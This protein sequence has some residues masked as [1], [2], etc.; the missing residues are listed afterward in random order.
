MIK[1]VNYCWHREYN[2]AGGWWWHWLHIFKLWVWGNKKNWI[3]SDASFSISED[4]L[5]A[6]QGLKKLSYLQSLFCVRQHCCLSI[7]SFFLVDFNWDELLS[8]VQYNFNCSSLPSKD[9]LESFQTLPLGGAVILYFMQL[10]NYI[11]C[12]FVL[13]ASQFYPNKGFTYLTLQNYFKTCLD[14]CAFLYI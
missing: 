10:H 8:V 9:W 1:L 14:S 4:E 5:A 2:F 13:S 7:C 6:K 3:I 11:Y 12:L